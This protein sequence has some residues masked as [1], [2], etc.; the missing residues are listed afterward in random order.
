MNASAFGNGTET[1][2]ATV[3]AEVLELDGATVDSADFDIL[4]PRIPI[5]FLVAVSGR[6]VWQPFVIDPLPTPVPFQE[7]IPIPIPRQG[8]LPGPGPIP[9]PDPGPERLETLPAIP[10]SP[11]F[12]TWSTEELRLDVDGRYPQMTASGIITRGYFSRI[13]WIAKLTAAGANTW[14][15]AIWYKDGN[16]AAFPYTTVT[17]KAVRSFFP[18]Q[19]K[20][21][22]TFSGGGSPNRVRDFRWV[23]SHYDA[24]D[25]EFDTATGEAA[26]LDI[27]TCAHPNHPAGLPCTTLTIPEVYRR[28]GFQVTTSPGTSVV[29]TGIL[30]GPDARWSDS[31]MHDAMQTY[32]SR[33]A[34][35]AQWAMWVFFASLH[36]RGTS[37][38]GIMFDDIGPNHRQGTAIFNDAFISVPPAGDANPAAWVRRMIF[39]TACHEMGHGFNLAH[40]WD[41]SVGAPWGTPW[42]PLAD[43][44]EARSFMNYPDNVSGGQSAFFAD[45][46]YR[47]S[48]GELL[49]MRHAPRRFVQM[50]NADWFD[51]HGFQGA[52]VSPNPSLRL[53]LRANRDRTRFEF[54]E[55]VTL[56]LKLT[57]TSDQP[58]LVDSQLLET[59]EAL[60]VVIKR[61][62]RSARQ[63]VP[64][65]QYCYRPELQLLVPNQSL[66]APL[67]I[68]AG[69]NGWDIA[70]PGSYIVQVTVRVGD[71]DVVSSPLAIRVAPPLGYEDEVL[72]QDI[73]SDDV[74][75]ILAFGGSRVFHAGND[76]LRETV[77]RLPERRVALHA[78]KALG[79]AAAKDY[80]CLVQDRDDTSRLLIKVEESRPDE[81]AAL[82]AHALT[83]RPDAAAESLGH[84]TYRR[85]TEQLSDWL[86]E[87]GATDMAA[88]CQNVLYETLANREVRGR[89]VLPAVLQ[90]IAER[91]DALRALA[92]D[93]TTG[94]RRKSTA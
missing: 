66:Y 87:K 91:R 3:E 75:R 65:G 53:E 55:P 85:S 83:N 25:F 47:F 28:A 24:V 4:F 61:A 84:I 8:P 79:N 58:T 31:E 60:T 76:V 43:E 19:R 38:G 72:A 63:Y 27:Q 6:Y 73:I 56:E 81:A 35:T 70:E 93:R 92:P 90:E 36:E 88:N 74:G 50:G 23:S 62:D 33:F 46:D 20:A 11:I 32:W 86:A 34:N 82:L 80:K 44:P 59:S 94:G 16:T 51:H 69:R 2:A 78:A 30:A 49:F 12:P 22:A 68:S 48:D 64:Y 42:I 52:A 39:W 17:I 5:P 1:A 45:F 15:G 57:N 77:E 9:G 54:L 21:T 13:H 26:T 40:S 71:E 37:L 41:K 7:P 89:P 67:S 18:A 29:P 10:I 14:S